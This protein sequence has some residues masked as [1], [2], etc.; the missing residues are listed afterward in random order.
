MEIYLYSEINVLTIVL[1]S[2]MA[3]KASKFGIET[4]P[5]RR[6]FVLSMYFAILTNIAE[7]FWDFGITGVIKYPDYVMH[8]IN[9]V[10]FLSLECASYSWYVYSESVNG[11]RKLGRSKY[12]LLEH[13]PFVALIVLLIVNS[14]TGCLYTY[15]ENF[16]EIPGPLYLAQ[17]ALAF[18]YVILAVIINVIRFIKGTD[19]QR[20]MQSSTMFAYAIPPVVCAILQFIFPFLPLLSV[21]PLIS[22]LLIY[23]TSLRSQVMLDP[24]TGI[25]NRKALFGELV[26]KTKNVR[27]NRK[28]YFMF[29]DID[30]FKHINDTYGHHCGDKALQLVA[31]ALKSLCADTNSYCARFGG[32][33]FALIVELNAGEDISFIYDTL[34]RKITQNSE[35]FNLTFPIAV[36]VGHAEFIKDAKS[37]QSLMNF[38]DKEMYKN[39]MAKQE[40]K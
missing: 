17:H 28:L 39:K 25:N 38:A 1:L 6:F 14:F 22:F 20:K 4:S 13:L 36:S 24:L 34:E 31:N 11:N 12:K 10:Y 15:G 29:I 33:E 5:K 9:A 3:V 30:N 7:F 18:G 19:Y 27:V 23:T 8:I 26:R 37:A 32:D 21:C 16:E 35:D 40:N 2:I